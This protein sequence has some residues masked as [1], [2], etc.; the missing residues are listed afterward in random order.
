MSEIAGHR[1]AAGHAA[2][3]TATAAMCAQR[4][5]E[6]GLHWVEC[7]VIETRQPTRESGL[8][9]AHD[10]TLCRLTQEPAAPRIS[11]LT[12]EEA[13]GFVIL[14]DERLATPAQCVPYVSG[15]NKIWDVKGAF[16]D[17][18]L[19]CL[20]DTL[21]QYEVQGE[22]VISSFEHLNIL[23]MQRLFPQFAGF[24]AAGEGEDPRKIVD[25]AL[26][27]DAQ[28]ITV[29]HSLLNVAYPLARNEG[30][31]VITYTINSPKLMEQI[32]NDYP[33]TVIC[34]DH[35]G[36]FIGATALSDRQVCSI[37]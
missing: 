1:F 25:I 26:T 29:H 9:L 10:D 20:G 18:G 31:R 2:E 19:L 21:V 7:D 33:E 37:Y 6:F 28:G 32:S 15:M 13:L 34:T 35:P 5:A 17:E 14:E 16:S 27:A 23:A 22:S 8:V 36:L 3:N 11:D 30:L 24:V 4:L 12:L